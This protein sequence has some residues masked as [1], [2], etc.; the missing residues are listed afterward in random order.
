MEN[1]T[2]I[3]KESDLFFNLDDTQLAL[4]NSICI[5]S[6]HEL[7]ERIFDENSKGTDLFL[8]LQGQ[9][10]IAVNPSLVSASSE[11]TGKL[12]IIAT[13]RSGQS[14]G[15]VTLV[16]QGLRSA[17]AI[18]ATRNT[19]LLRIPQKNLLLFC[20]HYPEMG[21][22]IMFNLAADLAQK[23]RSTDMRLREEFERSANDKKKR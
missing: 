9:V 6:K 3:L 21:Y 8:I 12:E 1:Y 4:I 16:D 14:F 17:A 18:S 19:L 15:E 11:A 22:K 13:L 20:E 5:L 2:H 7:N 23:L 10:H